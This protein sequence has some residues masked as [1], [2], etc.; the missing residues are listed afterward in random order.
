MPPGA[1]GR[2]DLTLLLAELARRGCNEV[3]AEAGATLNGAL[4]RAGL[5]DEWLAY[6]APMAM[7][8]PARGLFDFPELTAMDGCPRFKSHDL[9]QLGDDIRLTLR[10]A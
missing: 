4:L 8:Q 9:R 5:V 2:V 3:H 1:D 10:P 7:G 6:L